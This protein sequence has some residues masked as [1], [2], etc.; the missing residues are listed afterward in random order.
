MQ[1]ITDL[2]TAQTAGFSLSKIKTGEGTEMGDGA[3]AWSADVIFAGKKIGSA[4]HNGDGAPASIDI[5]EPDQDRLVVALKAAGYVLDLTVPDTKYVL[6][7]PTTSYGYLE[8]AFPHFVDQYNELKFWKG[9][10]KTK[11]IFRLKGAKPEGFLHFNE[12]YSEEMGAMLRK[13]YGDE[14]DLILNEAIASL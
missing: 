11:S 3:P 12:K 7:E 1:F 10:C 5:S 9:K 4:N 8:L 6:D 13:R 14:L 2:K